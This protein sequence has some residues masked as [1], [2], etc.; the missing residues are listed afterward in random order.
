M[1]QVLFF[2]ISAA[3]DEII[4]FTPYS[5]TCEAR[6]TQGLIDDLYRVGYPYQYQLR[7]TIPTVLTKIQQPDIS[8]GAIKRIWRFF[9]YSNMA[10]L[11]ELISRMISTIQD[12]DT[13]LAGALKLRFALKSIWSCGQLSLDLFDY[14]NPGKF[15]HVVLPII[16]KIQNTTNSTDYEVPNWTEKELEVGTSLNLILSSSI[17]DIISIIRQHNVSGRFIRELCDLVD[18]TA[19]SDMPTVMSAIMVKMNETNP[20]C[21]FLKLAKLVRLYVPARLPE[22]IPLI[23]QRMQQ[24]DIPGLVFEGWLKAVEQYAPDCMPELVQ[25]ALDKIPY[26]ATK[27]YYSAVKNMVTFVHKQAPT[28]VNDILNALRMKI[29]YDQ[30]Y[31]EN[32][33]FLAEFVEKNAPLQ[34]AEIIPD[35]ITTLRHP[36]TEHNFVEF[37]AKFVHRH[38]PEHLPE[39]IPD[40]LTMKKLGVN[41][42]NMKFLA[43]FI[44]KNGPQYICEVLPNIIEGINR[45]RMFD[46]QAILSLADFISEYA[47]DPTEESVIPAETGTPLASGTSKDVSH[48]VCFEESSTD[49][50]CDDFSA[51]KA[52]EES[53]TAVVRRINTPEI[54][55]SLYGNGY[56]ERY[57]SGLCCLVRFIQREAPQHISGLIPSIISK[58]GLLHNFYDTQMAFFNMFLRDYMSKDPDEGFLNNYPSKQDKNDFPWQ[59]VIDE[60]KR[61]GMYD[62]FI[63]YVQYDGEDFG[64]V[65]KMYQV[66]GLEYIPPKVSVQEEEEDNDDDKKWSS[67]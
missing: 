58:F 24:P 23:V 66:Q 34:V 67:E 35:I 26:T 59:Q 39:V 50:E 62:D 37:L 10:C 3:E 40:T 5:L 9:A 45:S 36:V 60:L 30:E 13:T 4:Y 25:P 61:I 46:A 64:I 32:T 44:R 7:E 49:E 18:D 63:Y 47:T 2:F 19:P 11:E 20:V 53:I 17:P 57:A 14:L 55:V 22:V 28:R 16:K 41:T 1:L 38:A 12:P 6:G 65:E 51:G 56:A 27:G 8:H 21:D 52:A 42:Y 15:P 48:N 33:R 31:G 43:E 29:K 54:K